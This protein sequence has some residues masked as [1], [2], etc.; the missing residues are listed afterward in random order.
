[1][2][3]L[4]ALWDQISVDPAALPVSE[5]HLRFAEERLMR[6]REDPSRGHS[7]FDVLDRLTG[8]ANSK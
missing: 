7:A 4:Q 5:S 1:M 6:Y 2:R 8:D 3:Y